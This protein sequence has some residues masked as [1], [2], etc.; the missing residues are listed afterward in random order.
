MTIHTVL[1]PLRG[2]AFG[3]KG[4]AWSMEH[5]E[6][7]VNERSRVVFFVIWFRPQTGGKHDVAVAPM[8]S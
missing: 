5:N 7:Q 2:H 6:R 3:L 8:N 4:L 1:A